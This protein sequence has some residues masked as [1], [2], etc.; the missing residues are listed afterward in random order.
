[1]ELNKAPSAQEVNRLLLRCNSQT[2]SSKKLA[3]ALANSFCNLSILDKKTTKLCGFVR[4]TTDQGLNANLWDLV[5][6]PGQYQR[7]F[8]AVLIHHSLVIIRKQLPGCS[9]S[10]PA[11]PTAIKALENEG[12]IID[13]NGI[14]SMAY[15]LK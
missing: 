7:N 5:A 4:I 9:V 12:F 6:A 3:F 2:Y 15:R 10:V 1:M 13:P 11:P 8:L 14:R